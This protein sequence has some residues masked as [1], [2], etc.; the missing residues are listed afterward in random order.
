MS[1]PVNR[2]Q[3]QFGAST[4]RTT[5]KVRDHMHPWIQEFIRS[6]PFVVMATANRE[7]HCDASPR[8]GRP[9]F[10]KVIDE[11]TLVMPDVAGNRLFHSYSNID[12]NPEVGLVFFVPGVQETAR[13]N[14]RVRIIADAELE[15]LDVELAVFDPDERA[16]NLQGLWIDVRE[17]YGHCPRALKHARFWN[18][19]TIQNNDEQPPVPKRPPGV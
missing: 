3:E 18:M 14:G 10:V 11:R 9:G 13:V 17:A 6:A 19:E 15:R 16:K 2:F 1:E 8:G 5:G 12:E 4:E 7:G